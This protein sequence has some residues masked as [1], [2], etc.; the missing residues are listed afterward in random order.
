MKRDCKQEYQKQYGEEKLGDKVNALLKF[1]FP[2]NNRSTQDHSSRG[3]VCFLCLLWVP[4]KSL[5][6]LT[7]L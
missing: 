4:V 1:L 6:F 3:V 7:A 2:S 5:G